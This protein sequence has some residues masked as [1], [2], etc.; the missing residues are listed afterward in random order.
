MNALNTK[1]CVLFFLL[2]ISIFCSAPNPRAK[3]G[4]G[5]FWNRISS[6]LDVDV[7]LSDVKFYYYNQQIRDNPTVI[8]LEE[9]DGNVSTI[10]DPTLPSYFISHGSGDSYSGMMSFKNLIL[11]LEDANVFL[12]DWSKH[13]AMFY[14]I[15]VTCV[16]KLTA[17]MGEA[18]DKYIV[19]NNIPYDN[20]KLIGHSLGSHVV[21]GIGAHLKGKANYIIGLDPAA[22]LFQNEA[23]ENRL[24]STDAQY[25]QILHTNG[26]FQGMMKS[27]GHADFYPNGGGMSQPGCGSDLFGSCAHAR[28]TAIFRESLKTGGFC[29]RNCSSYEDYKN[30]KCDD[31]SVSY[32][33]T[34]SLDKTA[35]GSFYFDT[36]A[37]SPYATGK[38]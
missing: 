24:D 21:G 18:V 38:C 4:S 20:I 1:H 37:K 10:L 34:I 35:Q 15:V 3:R 29:G 9:F 8:N 12:V 33:G 26:G 28:A 31:N 30:G 2:A 7:S 17:I 25:V 14:T 11:D 36:N 6:L 5:G 16:P 27:I 23:P 13:A 32:F 22:P 19:I